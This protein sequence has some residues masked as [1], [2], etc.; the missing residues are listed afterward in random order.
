MRAARQA[1]LTVMLDGQ[2]A[3]ETL[4]G[5]HGY[6]GPY[7]ADLLARGR[8]RRLREEVGA[9]RALHGATVQ[10]TAVDVARPFLPEPVRRR[11][12]ARARG[13]GELLGDALRGLPATLEP[14]GVP[15]GGRL[16]RQLHLILTARGLP[17]L[18]RYED[19]NSMAHSLEARVPFLD[20]RLV[21]LLFSLDAR[22]LIDRG[23][24]KVVLRRALGDLLPPVVRDRV[25]KLGFVTPEGRWLRGALGDLAAEVFASREFAE[26]GFVDA[27]AARRRLERHR[28]GE[29]EAGF[30]LWR[31]LSSE[32]WARAFLA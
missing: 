20:Y 16:R 9:Y 21:E 25:D 30:E 24:T 14:N 7:F 3:D 29:V 17:E 10:R 31:A 32:L 19:R 8:L 13:G 2:G 22:Q 26:R 15:F 4:A 28:R 1:G 18:L 11:G 5:Y 6:F 12:R 27:A 23:R